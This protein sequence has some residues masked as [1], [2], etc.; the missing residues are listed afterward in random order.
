MMHS[1]LILLTL[2]VMLLLLSPTQAQ[3]TLPLQSPL[4]GIN[5]VQ[6]D[7]ILLYDVTN[8]HYRE[9]NFGADAHHLWDF[10]PDGCRVL[11]TLSDGILPGKLYTAKLDGSD[12]QPAVTYDELDASA[13]GI[14]EA[15][16]EFYERSIGKQEIRNSFISS[17]NSKIDV[18][19]M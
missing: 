13:W 11:F 5:T 3:D 18:H 4:M 6:Q 7:A 1:K 2:S 9:L 15:A 12:M 10:S 17:L 14:I 16:K 19:V 8:N